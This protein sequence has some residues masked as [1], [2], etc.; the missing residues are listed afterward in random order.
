MWILLFNTLKAH[1]LTLQLELMAAKN[2]K[3]EAELNMRYHKLK[4][5]VTD[6]S[7]Q[8]RIQWIKI[9]TE[10]EDVDGSIAKLENILKEFRGGKFSK[11]LITLKLK[12]VSKDSLTDS[13]VLN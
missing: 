9:Y 7:L 2:E 13:T 5:E 1:Y 6:F 4:I 10:P 11:C 3:R 12:W 8:E